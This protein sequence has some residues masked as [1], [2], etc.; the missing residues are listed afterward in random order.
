MLIH[1][2]RLL[3]ITGWFLAAV[4]CPLPASAIGGSG[5]CGD[6]TG[7][8]LGN[9]LKTGSV[10]DVERELL[11]WVTFEENSQSALAK[12]FSTEQKRQE[13]RRQRLQELVEGVHE[14]GAVCR[15][16]PLVLI[17]LRAGNVEV[18]RYLVN[19]PMTTPP[20]LPDRVLFSCS[21]D[22]LE[23]D[24]L[25]N[26]R[27]KAFE[28]VLQTGRVDINELGEGD[29]TILQH[30][31][32]PELLTLF[33][34]YGA[35]LDVTSNRSGYP[36]NLLELAVLAAVDTDE[37][38]VTAKRL[39]AVQ[40]AQLFAGLT[41]NSIEGR[42]VE[43]HVRLSCNLQI[44]GKRWNPN[45]CNALSRFVKATPGTFGPSQ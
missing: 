38:G 20:K 26:R 37:N 7:G 31:T 25:R 32:E 12:L 27:R 4:C 10:A 34:E 23:D 14:K 9:A 42:P 39:H 33:V 13:W 28:V 17:A 1:T 22:Y 43:R 44:N 45:T 11:A 41:S 15:P 5:A 24:D 8:P 16:G 30:C 3:A 29:Q 40:R 21:H 2:F 36:Y 19:P 6:R 35:S 18:V